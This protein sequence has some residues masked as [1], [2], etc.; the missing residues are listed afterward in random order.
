MK[1]ISSVGI[2]AAA[3]QYEGPAGY[4]AHGR[5][6]SAIDGL[7]SGTLMAGQRGSASGVAT[8]GARAS[9]SSARIQSVVGLADEYGPCFLDPRHSHEHAQLLFAHTGVITVTTDTASFVVPP[10]RAVWIPAGTTHEVQCRERVSVHVMYIDSNTHP[11]L[12]QTCRVLEISGLLR[13]LI[14]EITRVVADTSD[15]ERDS[16]VVK[17]VLHEISMASSLHLQVPMPQD[18]RL[19]RVCRSILG[20]PAHDDTLDDWA[21]LIGM[22]RRT[23]TRMF[24]RETCMSFADWRQHVRLMEALSRLATG[25]SV[26]AVALDVGYNSPSAFTAMFRRTFGIAPRQYLKRSGGNK[27]QALY[28]ATST[29]MS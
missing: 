11:G 10:Q 29:L 19:T 28:S 2:A 13:E 18:P 1:R 27:A 21:R 6:L 8:C 12:P 3:A 22:G 23:F 24:R 26:L 25:E 17:L 9:D 7:Q 14:L 5:L 16:L 15:N 20:N 4:Q